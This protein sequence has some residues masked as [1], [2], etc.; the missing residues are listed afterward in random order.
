MYYVDLLTDL[1]LLFLFGFFLFSPFLVI[2]TLSSLIQYATTSDQLG[3]PK[4]EHVLGI[5]QKMSDRVLKY[6]LEQFT[7]L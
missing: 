1:Y 5:V 6:K 2:S 4:L 7:V 3:E